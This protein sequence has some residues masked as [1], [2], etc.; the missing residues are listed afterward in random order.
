M[1]ALTP[2]ASAAL[3]GVLARHAQAGMRT[4]IREIRHNGPNDFEI[5]LAIR[6]VRVC[7]AGSHRWQV[8]VSSPEGA[9]LGTATFSADFV[10][11]PAHIVNAVAE[12]L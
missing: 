1:P 5:V 3:E 11:T 6:T 9:P 10:Q 12:F 2:F 4:V 8:L 7:K